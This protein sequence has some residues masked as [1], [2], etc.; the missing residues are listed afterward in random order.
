VIAS[1]SRTKAKVFGVSWRQPL[2][3]S[4][5]LSEGRFFEEDEE[6]SHAQVCVIGEAVRRDLFG[7]SE[8]LG[9]DVK[10][11]DVWLQ[12]IG[13]L[14]AQDGS[15]KNGVLQDVPLTSSSRQ[16][17]V[18]FTTAMRKFE[19]DPL[20]SPLDELQVEIEPSVST[21]VAA[22]M[23][24]PLVDRLHAGAEDYELVVPETLLEQSRRTQRIF[25]IV[26]GSIAGIS[27]L[28][29]GIGIMNIMLASVLERT[30]E[31]GLRRALGAR[32]QDIRTQFM[33]ESFSI[34]FL[35]GAAGIIIGVVLA[36]IVA[37]FAGW[38]TVVSIWSIILSTGVS[39]SVGWASGIYPATRAAALDPI[40]ALRYE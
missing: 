9:K 6:V 33:I 25:N 14:K 28:V 17:F 26:M 8:A 3:T 15:G 22:S 35:G 1:G 38:P 29:G 11:N 18:P 31:I 5:P 16:I 32:Q 27:L 20:E 23:I 37:A 10:V 2:S 39:V 19:R 24:R 12:V 13:V 40:E 36:Q 30:R 34:S 7:F 4:I 21:S